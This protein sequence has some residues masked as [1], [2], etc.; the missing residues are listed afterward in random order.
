QV[1]RCG[2]PATR[3]TSPG[4]INEARNERTY[5]SDAGGVAVEADLRF[6][7]P[8]FCG[9]CDSGRLRCRRR[10]SAGVRAAVTAGMA[11]ARLA[12][13]RVFVNRRG[14]RSVRLTCAC[15]GGAAVVPG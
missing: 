13:D 4:G 9:V 8:V 1:C 12:L 2:R 7:G 10:V 6:H 5:D 3:V 14:G 15:R 11:G